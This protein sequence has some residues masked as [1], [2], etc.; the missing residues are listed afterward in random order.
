MIFFPCV[1]TEINRYHDFPLIFTKKNRDVPEI[2]KLGSFWG[3]SFLFSFQTTFFYLYA[4]KW[5]EVPKQNLLR[6]CPT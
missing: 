6:N 3:Q 2:V 5:Q 4:G 1:F